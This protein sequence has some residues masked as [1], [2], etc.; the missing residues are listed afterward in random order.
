MRFFQ[1]RRNRVFLS[2]DGTI[3]KIFKD[4]SDFE[5]EAAI[6]LRLDGEGAPRLLEKFGDTLRIEYID[7]KLLLDAYLESDES[8]AASLAYMLAD[9]IGLI[10]NKLSKLIPFDENFRN[11]IIS[12][13]SV[14]R[15]DL[16]ET[17][18]G[19]LEEW[20]AKTAAFAT[21][22][23]VS[24][25]VKIAFITTLFKTVCIDM[26]AIMPIYLA[27]LRFLAARWQVPFPSDVYE[28]VCAALQDNR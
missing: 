18:S 11:Y 8:I 20:C 4:A 19:I 27:E 14:V 2:N 17:Q 21:L 28:S 9:T 16:E 10:R 25:T 1:S 6:L 5:N 12:D 23:E 26:S 22:Y 24:Q 7:G 13:K 15:I 3:H